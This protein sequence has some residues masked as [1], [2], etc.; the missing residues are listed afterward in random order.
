[1]QPPDSEPDDGPLSSISINCDWLPL[2]RGA[3]T[4]LLM[5]ST[6]KTDIV[7]FET[8]QKRVMRLINM[9]A[10]K[11]CD[12]CDCLEFNN[13]V[14]N[15]GV[16]DGHGGTIFTPVD[17]R[18]EGTVPAPWPTPPSGQTGNCLTGANLADAFKESQRQLIETMGTEAGFL[19]VLEIIVN[20]VD[21]V[22][23]VIGIITNIALG[24][25][26]AAFEAGAS[27]IADAFN[28]TT[29]TAA[30]HAFQ[31]SISCK[32][33]TTGVITLQTIIDI[34]A[35]FAHRILTVVT[36]EPAQS[37]WLRFTSDWLDMYGPNGLQLLANKAGVSSADCSDCDCEWCVEW[38]FTT[39]PHGWTSGL[40]GHP[41]SSQ[42]AGHGWLSALDGAD[43]NNWITITGLDISN[44][45]RIEV[46]YTSPFAW[47][48]GSSVMQCALFNAGTGVDGSGVSA[49]PNGDLTVTSSISHHFDQ[50]YVWQQISNALCTPC[51][52]YIK[53]V[54]LYGTGDAP[55]DLLPCP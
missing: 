53:K 10:E 50:I 17:P 26:T 41:P 48:D 38:D 43:E 37:L 5:Q 49:G 4:Q 30:Y 1:V 40:F 42:V 6:W 13:G 32:V 44:A 28:L 46:T 20:L 35:D 51:D 7:S 15:K 47:S 34:K 18:T 54:H 39:G 14:W 9:F 21:F 29:R 2:I 36:D 8:T 31:C 23:P 22:V 25:A 33:G 55:I 27:A 3:L 11:D 45:T 52:W 19:G 16:P 24:L 12:V